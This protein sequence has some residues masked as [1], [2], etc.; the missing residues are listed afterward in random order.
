MTMNLFDGLDALESRQEPLGPGAVVLRGFAVPDERALLAALEDVV[1]RAPFRHMVT[2]GGFRMSV[3]MTNC[4]SLGWVTDRTGYR[5]DTIDPVSGRHWPPMPDC[6]L[7]LAT[8]AAAEAGFRQF[9][10]DAC[11]INRYEPGTQTVVASGQERAGLCSAYRL[12]LAR[13]SGGLFVRRVEE[14]R[15][16]DS[17]C[18]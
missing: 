3:A 14:S 11:L 8:R 2:P 12:C 7:R 1:A 15:Q 6:F 9:V 17:R 18:D 10:P 5:Y 13:N 16:I 4:G